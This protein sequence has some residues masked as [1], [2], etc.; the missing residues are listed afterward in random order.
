MQKSKCY[1]NLGRK[2]SD[3][4]MGPKKYWSTLTR[5]LPLSVK[6]SNTILFADDTAIY[7]SGKNCNE[8][9]NMMNEDLALVKK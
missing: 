9:Q 8:I 1:Q 7:Y 6:Y 3:P 4:N 2:L 5:L